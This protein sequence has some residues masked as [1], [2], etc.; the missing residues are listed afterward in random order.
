VEY[1][2]DQDAC[3]GEVVEAFEAGVEPF[4]VSGEPSEAS[5]PGEA[6]FH[7][8]P[9][10]QQHEAAFGLGV[11]QNFKLDAV[12]QGGFGRVRAGVALV[13]LGQ[14]NGVPG[15]LLHLFSQ[16]GDLHAIALMSRRDLQRHQVAQRVDCDVDLRALAPFGSVIA[17]PC[18]TLRR[19]LERTTVQAYRRRLAL[20]TA[21]LTQ[22]QRTSATG[23]SNTPAFIQRRIC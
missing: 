16:R 14:I 12:L 8:P 17:C 21:K 10:G 2:G 3:E 1:S 7:D 15:L 19:R 13:D 4:I 11:F 18:A 20:A 23:I 5:G 22:E 9:S 6:S